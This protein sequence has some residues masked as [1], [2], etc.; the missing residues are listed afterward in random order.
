MKKEQKWLAKTLLLKWTISV[1][2]IVNKSI[3]L[4]AII[5]NEL[6]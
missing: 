5:I 3:V 4:C 1:S 2:E 6:F